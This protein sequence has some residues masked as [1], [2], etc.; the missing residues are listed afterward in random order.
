MYFFQKTHFLLAVLACNFAFS[1][2]LDYKKITTDLQLNYIPA[3]RTWLT[4]SYLP[5]LEGSVLFIGVQCYN[6]QYHTYVPNP[7]LFE[8]IESEPNAAKFGSPY[9]HHV[10][11]IMNFVPNEL[12]DNVCFFGILG[13]PRWGDFPGEEGYY[14]NNDLEINHAIDKVDSL[15]KVGG[16]LQISANHDKPKFNLDY[17]LEFFSLNKTLENYEI[18]QLGLS[19]AN[20][21]W[22]GKKLT[23]TP[24]LK[25]DK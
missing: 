22:W 6:D 2:T 21:I 17:W 24:T 4:Q 14:F 16:T 18:L 25:E 1:E 19:D 12:Y 15:V 11:N 9:R 5:N 23:A 10:A 3:E 13:F 20:V 7:K 8:T